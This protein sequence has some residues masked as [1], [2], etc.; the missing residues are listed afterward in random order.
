MMFALATG[1]DPLTTF[2]EHDP[3]LYQFAQV[4]FALMIIAYLVVSILACNCGGGSSDGNFRAAQFLLVCALC[5]VYYGLVWTPAM[6]DEGPKVDEIFDMLGLQVEVKNGKE[7]P[8]TPR[9]LV[10]LPYLLVF[11]AFA[12]LTMFD[13]PPSS[14]SLVA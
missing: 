8:Q 12:V 1:D 13:S 7:E 14:K 6:L 2:S 5:G 9:V 11:A 4:A 3:E 10:A